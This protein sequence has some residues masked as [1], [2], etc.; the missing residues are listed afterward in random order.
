MRLQHVRATDSQVQGGV[1]ISPVC[2]DPLAVGRVCTYPYLHGRGDAAKQFNL[3]GR[4][5]AAA[6]GIF[7]SKR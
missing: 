1:A 4:H 2:F 3:P 7:Y 6:S 5:T